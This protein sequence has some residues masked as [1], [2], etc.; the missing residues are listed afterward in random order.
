MQVLGSFMLPL[1]RP[2]NK[3]VLEREYS[4]FRIALSNRSPRPVGTEMD[5]R[6]ESVDI[7]CRLNGRVLSRC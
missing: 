3:D 7:G 6:R 5:R 1:I 4:A 2:N